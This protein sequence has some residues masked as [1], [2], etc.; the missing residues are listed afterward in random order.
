[1]SR[2]EPSAI[3]TS[4]AAEIRGDG[5]TDSRV[6]SL[7][8]RLARTLSFRCRTRSRYY[9]TV[10]ELRQVL[11]AAPADALLELETW[12]PVPVRIVTVEEVANLLADL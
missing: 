6:F 11:D 8:E 2:Y 1:M 4:F 12:P 3:S 5:A 9:L 7:P 10:A